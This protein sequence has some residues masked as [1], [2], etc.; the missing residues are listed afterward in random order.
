MGNHSWPE[1]PS[2]AIL[3]Q[4]MPLDRFSPEDRLNTLIFYL[5]THRKADAATLWDHASLL[6]IPPGV[7]ETFL[8]GDIH[9]LHAELQQAG[10]WPILASLLAYGGGLAADLDVLATA[11]AEYEEISLGEERRR[12]SITLKGLHQRGYR[13]GRRPRIPVEK[14]TDPKR[15]NT[16][17]E[18][19]NAL[20]LLRSS[21]GD[22]PYRDMA[23]RSQERHPGWD[24]DEHEPRSHTGLRNVVREGA[25]PKLPAVLA[26]VRG[27][28]ITDPQVGRSWAAAHARAAVHLELM[29]SRH[30]PRLEDTVEDWASR[31]PSGPNPSMA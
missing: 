17:P 25:T 10:G 13:V 14:V 28:G 22:I 3:D 29:H 8:N 15:V 1:R 18:L 9:T 19:V 11:Q 5:R 24:P 31:S 16:F 26:F 2:Q 27:C 30:P 21:R 12:M 4:Q 23:A 6:G 20:T 7:V